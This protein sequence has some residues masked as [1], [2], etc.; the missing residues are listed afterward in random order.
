MKLPEFTK[1]KRKLV[2]GITL[3]IVFSVVGIATAQELQ[4]SYTVIN[5][6]IA[7]SLDPGKFTEGTTKII[8]ETN[9]PLTF[10]LNVQ[11]YNVV[12]KIGTPNIYPPNTLD[13]RFSAASWIGLS[14]TTFTLAP[15]QKQIVNYY[16]QV[17]NT[18]RPG[19]HYAA[20][21]Y[22]PVTPGQPPATGGVVNT[23]IGALFYVTI[24][25]PIKENAQITKFFT[26]AFQEYGPVNILTEITNFGDLHILPKGKV[27]VTGLFFNKSQ[28]LVE[29]NIFPG[30]V[31]RQFTNT[32]GQTLMLGRYKAELLASYGKENNLPLM[33]TLYFWVIP[34]RLII[35]II[36]LVVAIV[37][38]KKYYDKRKE[39]KSKEPLEPKDEA[40]ETEVKST[41]ESSKK[42][43]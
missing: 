10:N 5:P 4:R 26:N 18:A 8:N 35:V 27:S 37:L 22:A 12:D 29:S 19:G 15:Q 40:S 42:V 25:G 6:Q 11:D 36:L 13:E 28:D 1:I 2:L 32:M 9:E 34:W 39:K 21:V 33:A 7:V 20:I 43:G 14:P 30:G 23:Q 24:N 31:T 3:T 16:I 38:G 17:P 41:S